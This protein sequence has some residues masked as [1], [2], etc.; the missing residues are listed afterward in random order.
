M[1]NKHDNNL[2]SKNNINWNYIQQGVWVGGRYELP[3]LSGGFHGLIMQWAKT[4]AGRFKKPKVL[5]VSE[6]L[7][8]KTHLQKQFLN[9]E[10]ETMDLYWDLQS[11]PD[12]IADLC[13]HNSL[14]FNKYDLVIN[15][16]VL[17]HVYDPFTAM[18]NMI[19]SLKSKGFLISATHPP[20]F[21]YH[22]FPRDYMRFIIDW[23]YDIPNYIDGVTLQELYQLNQDYVFTTYEKL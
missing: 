7:D 10:I 21:G 1:N 11:K 8:V 12:I 15:H 20:N 23:W 3:N 9:W 2:F 6:G 22:Q 13:K 19:N 14:P 18:K 5:L 16:S 17:E 4:Y